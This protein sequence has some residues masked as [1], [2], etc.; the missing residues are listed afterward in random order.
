MKNEQNKE[1]CFYINECVLCGSMNKY[2]D[3]IGMF[4][5]HS[6]HVTVKQI[7]LWRGWKEEADASKLEVPFVFVKTTNKGKS[8]SDIRKTGIDDI[9]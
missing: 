1:A 8:V 5:K 6:F 2:N 7:N 3:V 4:K 9:I